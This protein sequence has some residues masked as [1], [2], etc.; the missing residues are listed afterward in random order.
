MSL[1]LLALLTPLRAACPAS[2]WDLSARADRAVAAY[3]RLEVERFQAEA[4]ELSLELPCLA[5]PA[6]PEAAARVHLVV[7]LNA[8]TQ[9]DEDRVHEA[10]RGLLS[11]QPD[12]QP[13]V[14]LAPEGSGLAAAFERAR[15]A[16]PG[17]SASIPGLPLVV[18]GHPRAPLPTDRA[19]V[20]QWNVES[21]LQSRY[22]W[23]G[24]LDAEL[25]RTARISAAAQGL[26]DPSSHRSRPLAIAGAATGVVALLGARQANDAYG[27]FHE[28]DSLSEAQRYYTRNRVFALGSGLAAAGSA[29]LLLGAVVVR[30]W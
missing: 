30:E 28:T 1:L 9:R 20:V 6:S 2:A 24:A 7:A 29:G 13:G 10:L 26:P 25:R 21:G 14:S 4:L 3:E 15:E 16:G 23:A 17:S 8:W 12:Y 22:A 18:D 5:E 11:L 19:A 27:A